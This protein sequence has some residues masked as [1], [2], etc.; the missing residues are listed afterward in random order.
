MALAETFDATVNEI[1]AKILRP[2]DDRSVVTRAAERYVLEQ[3]A[4][5]HLKYGTTR[6]ASVSQKV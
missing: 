1:V 5:L 4:A 2:E 6:F 3:V